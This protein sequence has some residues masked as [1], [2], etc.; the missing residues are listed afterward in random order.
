MVPAIR[1]DLLDL[2]QGPQAASFQAL[3]ALLINEAAG[4]GDFVIV[5]DDFHVLHAPPILDM[6]GYLL[7]HLPPA[8]HIV[9]L[10]RTDPALPLSRLRARGQMLEI[11]AEQLRFTRDEIAQ[12]FADSHGVDTERS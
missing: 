10:S 2:V 6:L 8:M 9:L 3:M 5:L 7:E 1:P 11:R 12:F 4:A